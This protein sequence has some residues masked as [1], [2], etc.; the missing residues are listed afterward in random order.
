[1]D[2]KSKYHNNEWLFLCNKTD[3]MWFD[4][5][6]K[7]SFVIGLLEEQTC[8]IKGVWFCYKYYNIELKPLGC[9]IDK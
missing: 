8:M 3:I 5:N 6:G 7:F 4:C 1:M 9:R 2:F